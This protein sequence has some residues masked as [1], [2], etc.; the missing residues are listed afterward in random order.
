MPNDDSATTYQM[1]GG[2][3]QKVSPVPEEISGNFFP[4]DLH[5][6][7]DVFEGNDDSLKDK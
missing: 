1:F 3:Q 5:R 7:F 4:E 2:G 6:E